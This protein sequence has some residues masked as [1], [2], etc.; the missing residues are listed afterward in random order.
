MPGKETLPG[1]ALEVL[2]KHSKPRALRE[3]KVSYV[4]CA[5]S[6]GKKAA[7]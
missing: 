2:H 5:E 4:W 1:E 6:K 3:L 7:P